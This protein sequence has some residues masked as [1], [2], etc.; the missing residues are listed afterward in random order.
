MAGAPAMVAAGGKLLVSKAAGIAPAAIA[1]DA[2]TDAL[3]GDY[4]KAGMK[5]ASAAAVTQAAK[6]IP[7]AARVAGAAPAASPA[8]AMASIISAGHA[9][10]MNPANAPKTKKLTT[11]EV[12]EEELKRLVTG[13]M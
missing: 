3:Q 10:K 4:K 1:L 7:G 9:A 2:G 12:A 6:L 13:G 5:A 11:R 8:A